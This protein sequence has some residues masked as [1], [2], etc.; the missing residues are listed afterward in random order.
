[1]ADRFPSLE[2]FDDGDSELQP[3]PQTALEGIDGNDDFLSRERAALGDDASQ[4]GTP[5]QDLQPRIEEGEADLLGGDGGFVDS[6]LV[7]EDVSQFES[8]FPNIDT[9]NNAVGPSGTITGSATPFQPQTTYN[10]YTP[11]NQQESEP[12]KEWR[13]RRDADLSKRA[14]VSAEK[15]DE[16]LKDARQWIDEFYENY[17]KKKDRVIGQSRADADIFLANKDDTSSGGT[18]WERISKL[19]DL[20]GKGNKGG[21]A[22]SG[23]EK[24]KELLIG[25]KK[26]EKAPGASG[27]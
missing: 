13:A 12:M 18:S 19:I 6:H 3:K 16:T 21:A 8:S 15:K 27:L 4:F 22:G 5:G 10:S 25:L 23:K 7:G 1:M 24:F 2:E 11:S 26:D 17:N 14:K 9:E 20:S